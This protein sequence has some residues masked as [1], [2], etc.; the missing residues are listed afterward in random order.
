VIFISLFSHD[1]HVPQSP[2]LT[3]SI[4]T[5]LKVVGLLVLCDVYMTMGRKGCRIWLWAT[6][7]VLLILLVPLFPG[8]PIGQA[9]SS[10]L[11]TGPA[12][13]L[14]QS[15]HMEPSQQE[16]TSMFCGKYS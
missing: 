15:W 3:P 6:F 5:L 9:I 11:L 2:S 10:G 4:Y 1:E 16:L 12:K 8:V 13:Y 7:Q 14:S